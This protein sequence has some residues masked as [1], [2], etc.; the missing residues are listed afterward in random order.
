MS[1][2]MF[3]N[4]ILYYTLPPTNVGPDWPLQDTCHF[5]LVGRVRFVSY[6]RF[7]SREELL[8]C[9]WGAWIPGGYVTAAR[10]LYDKSFGDPTQEDW[11][12]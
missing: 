6:I 4:S 12:E 3:V 1:C 2:F 10:L 9:Q 5:G 11:T 7:L 8:L